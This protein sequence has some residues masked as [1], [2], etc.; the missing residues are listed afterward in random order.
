MDI[1]IVHVYQ[2]A[3]LVQANSVQEA[4][5]FAMADLYTHCGDP[6]EVE[7]V[8]MLTTRSTLIDWNNL[9]ITRLAVK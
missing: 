4:Q 1:Y 7:K 9:D 6:V 3:V 5:A 8:E 2:G